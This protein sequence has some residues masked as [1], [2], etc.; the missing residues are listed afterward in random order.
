MVKIF[1][2]WPADVLII[3]P[4][5]EGHGYYFRKDKG[6]R[7]LE[8]DGGQYYLLK[9]EKQITKAYDYDKFYGNTIILYRKTK[10]ELVPCSIKGDEITPID[11]D[12]KFWLVQKYRYSREKYDKPSFMQKYGAMMMLIV[13][14]VILIMIVSITFRGFSDL[15]AN[16]VDMGSTL[17]TG[18]QAMANALSGTTVISGDMPPI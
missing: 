14:M 10:D 9:K 4:R 11:Q 13:L 17:N 18:M 15:S 1:N 2:R 12:M 6:K 3:E 16:L 8:K 5:E 7:I